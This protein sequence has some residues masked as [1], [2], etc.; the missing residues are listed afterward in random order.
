MRKLYRVATALLLSVILVIGGEERCSAV[1]ND[2][3]INSDLELKVGEPSGDGETIFSLLR[4]ILTNT[5]TT[6]NTLSQVSDKI[7]SANATLTSFGDLSAKYDKLSAKLDTVYVTAAS[8]SYTNSQVKSTVAE[9]IAPSEIS[10]TWDCT[11]DNRCIS[12]SEYPERIDDTVITSFNVYYSDV[13]AAVKN[14]TLAGSVE[15]DPGMLYTEDYNFI[16]NG[17]QPDKTYYIW[18]SSVVGDNDNPVVLK[19]NSN[20]RVLKTKTLQSAQV[21]GLTSQPL[22]IDSIQINWSDPYTGNETISPQI[23]GYNCYWSESEITV[24]N[25]S[26]CSYKSTD[27]CSTSV[28]NLDATIYYYIAVVPIMRDPTV[29]LNLSAICYGR[30]SLELSSAGGRLVPVDLDGDGTEEAMLCTLTF[31]NTGQIRGQTQATLDSLV[32]SYFTKTTSE[33]YSSVLHKLIKEDNVPFHILTNTQ[34]DTLANQNTSIKFIGE[35]VATT[36]A[37]NLAYT[38]DTYSNQTYTCNSHQ[39]IFYEDGN[40]SWYCTGGNWNCGGSQV[41]YDTT[42]KTKKTNTWSGYRNYHHHA[43]GETDNDHRVMPNVN[44]GL[45]GYFLISDMQY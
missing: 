5:F 6:L 18:V 30:A 3:I 42:T 26:N 19:D 33:Y 20:V 40:C 9:S 37:I 15:Y 44:V 10:V 36:A 17:L 13:N 4:Q 23:R 21:T 14:M 27:T 8:A 1:V 25:L 29:D 2:N 24:D 31:G 11:K 22:D 39:Q 32:T 28:D 45:A 43:S 7:D 12:N 41:Y 16:V 34:I 35:N 38:D